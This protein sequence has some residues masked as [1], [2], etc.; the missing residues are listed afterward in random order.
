MG[1]GLLRTRRG[2]ASGLVLVYFLAVAG[3]EEVTLLSGPFCASLHVGKRGPHTEPPWR[4]WMTF[5]PFLPRA[6]L[7]MPQGR[8]TA[9]EIEAVNTAPA[10]LPDGERGFGGT[11]AGRRWHP[12]RRQDPTTPSLSTCGTGSQASLANRCS[13]E[14]RKGF[15]WAILALSP[16][17]EFQFEN[18]GSVIFFK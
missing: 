15:A 2:T 6:S 7:L 5:F 16:V 3:D 8:V 1:G 11:G 14:G 4:N 13:V 9:A 18:P 10:S 12:S 17:Y